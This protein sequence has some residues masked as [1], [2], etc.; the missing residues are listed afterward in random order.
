MKNFVKSLLSFSITVSVAIISFDNGNVTYT[1]LDSFGIKELALKKIIL[2]ALI[3]FFIASINAVL[4]SIK[5]K[6]FNRLEVGLEFQVD[7]KNI[8]DVE[9]IPRSDQYHE[10]KIDIRLIITPG[11]N[12]SMFFLKRFDFKIDVFFNP[13]ILDVTLESDP[14]FTSDL[15]ENSSIRMNQEGILSFFPLKNFQLGG[16]KKDTFHKTGSFFIKPIRLTN[17]TTQ[18]DFKLNNGFLKDLIFCENFSAISKDE[19]NI[20][21][22]REC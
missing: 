21:C 10:K 6:F 8:R 7:G 15:E 1:V 12:I 22:K 9:F 4:L 16:R 5:N 18:I 20:S 3:A 17:D 19:L 2:T 13:T 11:S 14:S